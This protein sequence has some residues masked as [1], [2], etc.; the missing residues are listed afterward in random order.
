M[1]PN[2]SVLEVNST[3]A[4]QS[5][6]FKETMG[7]ARMTDYMDHLVMEATEIQLHPN[8]CHI[9]TGFFQAVHGTW[10]QTK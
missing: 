3:E 10:P 9:D 8:N 1:W 5:T 6:N 4:M 7:L 2:K